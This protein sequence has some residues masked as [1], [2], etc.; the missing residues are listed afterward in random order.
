MATSDKLAKILETKLN[1]KQA[2]QE[3][4][5][6][7]GDKF[8]EY[9]D[10]IRAIQGGGGEPSAGGGDLI[11]VENGTDKEYAKGD[12]VLINLGMVDEADLNES[13]TSTNYYYNP[14]VVFLDNDTVFILYRNVDRKYIWKGGKWIKN[15]DPASWNLPNNTGRTCFKDG[16]VLLTNKTASGNRSNSYKLNINSSLTINSATY[17]GKYKDKSYAIKTAQSE[18]YEYYPSSNTIGSTVLLNGADY[19]MEAYIDPDTGHGFII[20]YSNFMNAIQIDDNGAFQWRSEYSVPVS[21]DSRIETFTGFDFGDYM[22]FGTNYDNA[23]NKATHSGSSFF[24]YQVV[25]NS[26]NQRILEARPN[27][28]KEFQS[29]DAE[30]QFD[31][32]NDILTVGTKDEVYT[33]KLNRDTYEFENLGVV[34]ELPETTGYAR[35]KLAYSPDMTKAIITIRTAQDKMNYRIYGVYANKTKIVENDSARYQPVNTI[36]GFV[37]GNTDEEG[38]LEVKT[39][40]PEKVDITIT[41]DVDVKDDEIT[42]LGV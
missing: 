33:Y 26:N 15:T 38:K 29:I 24:A 3:K 6:E 12:K 8:A 21:S 36:T 20:N 17:M 31:M 14:G 37:T 35:Y 28:F 10:K 22:F 9:P 34:F 16:T 30:C 2:I 18:I 7:V 4:G 39:V 25:P 13:V 42:I 19:N 32:R 5:V 40:L 1:I 41:T 27:L 23:F 11:Y